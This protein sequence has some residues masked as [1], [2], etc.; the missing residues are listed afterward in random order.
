MKIK[1][2]TAVWNKHGREEMGIEDKDLDNPIIS[3]DPELH[4]LKMNVSKNKIG[5]PKMRDV[6][7]FPFFETKEEAEV[8]IDLN[9]HWR[10]VSVNVE[11]PNLIKVDN[12][13]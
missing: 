13:K 2:W 3:Q 11:I 6:E 4:G 5:R 12:N 1:L 7:M 9:D 10:A 8:F